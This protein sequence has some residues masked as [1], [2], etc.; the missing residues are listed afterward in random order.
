[1]DPEV[2]KPNQKEMNAGAGSRALPGGGGLK[3]APNL[4]LFWIFP[5]L[6][7]ELGWREC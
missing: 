4:D 6:S 1:M 2:G 5:E 7:V 3:E